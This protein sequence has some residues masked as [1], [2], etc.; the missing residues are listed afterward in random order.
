[1]RVSIAS[2]LACILAAGTVQAQG[3]PATS[4]PPP[5]SRGQ[6]VTVL[7]SIDFNNDAGVDIAPFNTCFAS[8]SAFA[9]YTYLTFAPKNAT[10]NFYKD[11]NCADFAFGLV[12][13]YVTHPGQ[14]KS[15]RWVGWTEDTIGTFFD[16]NPIQGQGDAV[17]GGYEPSPQTPPPS[18]GKNPGPPPSPPPTTPGNTNDN[19]D[20]N[21]NGGG[22]DSNQISISSTFFG[23]VF[24]TLAVLSIGGLIY[25][26]RVG[27]SMVEDKG[28]GVLPYDRVD[29]DEADG[30][31]DILLTSNDKRDNFELGD[32]ADDEDDDEDENQERKAHGQRA[33]R[34]DRYQDDDD[35]V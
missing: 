34:K 11:P 14:A 15:F 12:G 33:A 9:D 22:G 21:N 35:Q 10:I 19:K 8:E 4:P 27:K 25:W 5:P 2:L 31:E 17:N 20:Q 32:D 26:K 16:K 3:V 1:M 29:D 7:Y 28:K 6:A 13:Y 18:G 24:G 30:A 23:G